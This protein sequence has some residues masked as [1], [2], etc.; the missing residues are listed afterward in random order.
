MIGLDWIRLNNIQSN[1]LT[2]TAPP[3]F[4]QT[5]TGCNFWSRNAIENLKRPRKSAFHKEPKSD[6]KH[7]ESKNLQWEKIS[8]NFVFVFKKFPRRFSTPN[9]PDSDSSWNADI[10]RLFGKCRGS[11][12]SIV[13]SQKRT[14][15]DP[16]RPVAA[17]FGPRG[18]PQGWRDI[19]DF[20]SKYWRPKTSF[21]ES[22]RQDGSR[23]GLKQYQT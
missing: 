15:S 20:T 4:G 22:P 19:G 18:D 23:N 3:L 7:N 2:L 14:R 11:P 10:R 8:W 1:P 12:R 21:L 13:S 6:E 9:T 5:S 17:G 16:K